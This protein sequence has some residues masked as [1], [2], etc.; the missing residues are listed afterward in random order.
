M[1]LLLALITSAQAIDLDLTGDCPG[2]IRVDV[3]DASVSGMVAVLVGTEGAGSEP[4]P[5]GPCA[6]LETGLAGLTLVGGLRVDWDL[7]GAHALRLSLGGPRCEARIQVL[8]LATC[9]V[10]RAR[11]FVDPPFDLG[12]VFHS[13]ESE[14]RMVH[15]F[16]SDSAAPLADYDTFCE[17]RGLTW[18]EPRSAPDAQQ[19]IDEA[20][21]LDEYHTWIITKTETNAGA[22][23]FGGYPVVV[24]GAGGE[25]DDVG[26][27]A[28]RKWSTS[29]CDPDDYGVTKCW[30][31]SH[32]Y[33]WL[34]CQE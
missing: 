33:D 29:F 12:G 4:I 8:D 34:V 1:F 32:I 13:Y 26:H 16:K 10:T 31:D 24:D 27:T 30:D 18:F 25:S 5:A 20:Y 17:D 19:I 9:T 23:E 6:G 11:S 14:S 21:A 15:L 22:S 3:T 28:I 7:D 2:E